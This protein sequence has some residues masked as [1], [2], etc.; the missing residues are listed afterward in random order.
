MSVSGEEMARDGLETVALDAPDDIASLAGAFD[1]AR[2]QGV[3]AERERILGKIRREV[4][5]DDGSYSWDGRMALGK[6]LRKLE[7]HSEPKHP[8]KDY[9][10]HCNAALARALVQRDVVIAARFD[11]ARRYRET[12]SRISDVI[13]ACRLD[14]EPQNDEA[15]NP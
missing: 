5:T 7:A 9:C 15:P 13:R 12:L 11:D 3:Q 1:T 4:D 2:E 14:A 8:Q 6:L 10:V